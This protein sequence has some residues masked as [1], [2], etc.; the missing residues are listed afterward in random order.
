[1]A[2]GV[3]YG[4]TGRCAERGVPA[5]A[6]LDMGGSGAGNN[7]CVKGARGRWVCWSLTRAGARCAAWAVLVVLRGGYVGVAAAPSHG[8]GVGQGIPCLGLKAWLA[9]RCRVLGD[10]QGRCCLEARSPLVLRGPPQTVAH[11]C[12]CGSQ[13]K[14]GHAVHVA[15][16]GWQ[17]HGPGVHAEPCNC[18][19]LPS[20]ELYA[21]CVGDGWAPGRLLYVA[22][23]RDVDR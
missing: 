18:L 20:R 14:H 3:R 22:L 7:G 4:T 8:S 17:A 16:R 12:C 19:H 21:G 11:P 15:C 2:V 10:C 1:M 5:A 23:R 6:R 13:C 9:A